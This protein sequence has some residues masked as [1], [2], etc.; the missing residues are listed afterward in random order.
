MEGGGLFHLHRTAR[1]ARAAASGRRSIFDFLP[2]L[3]PG[4]SFCKTAKSRRE[5][6]FGSIDIAVVC[7]AAIAANPFSYSKACSTFRTAGRDGPAAR[8]SLGGVAFID[9]FKDDAGL[10]ALVF[11]HRLEH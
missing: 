11:Q 1:A 3:N 6:V 4:D 10:V 7:R 5:N 2:G 9:Y 8:T